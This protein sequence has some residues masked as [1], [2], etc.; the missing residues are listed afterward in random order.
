M[1]S[2]FTGFVPAMPIV[3]IGEDGV[4][5]LAGCRCTHCGAVYAQD[6]LACSSCCRRDAISAI[7]LG[8]KGRLY[9]FTIVHRSFPGVPVPF[10]SA[11]VDLD[12]GGTL[13]GTLIEAEPDPAKLPYDLSV[14]IVFRD[15]GQ[16]DR[17]GR[18]FLSYYFIPARRLGQ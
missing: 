16:V 3:R 5:F 13:R 12:D 9:N 6:R 8:G 15:S 7:R 4:P 18:S 17:E 14:D 10:I 1:T 11:I 2:N